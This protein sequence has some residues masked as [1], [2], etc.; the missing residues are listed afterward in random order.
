MP[1]T[2]LSITKW[3]DYS[4]AKDSMFVHTDIPEAPWHEVPS[5]DKRSRPDQHDVASA[6]ADTV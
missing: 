6:L 4:R 1:T 3:E 2:Y 5:V